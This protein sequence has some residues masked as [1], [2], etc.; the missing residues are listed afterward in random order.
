[1]RRTIPSRRTSPSSCAPACYAVPVRAARSSIART[2]K[3]HALSDRVSRR[4]LLRRTS[5]TLQSCRGRCGGMLLSGAREGRVAQIEEG[6]RQR[7]EL[8]AEGDVSWTLWGLVVGL[9]LDFSERTLLPTRSQRAVVRA[10]EHAPA[11]DI[12]ANDYDLNMRSD[13][14]SQF[15]VSACCSRCDDL[16]PVLAVIR[17]HRSGPRRRVLKWRSVFRL[18]SSTER[19]TSIAASG[20]R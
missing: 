17:T 16:C 4:R 11:G 7:Q 12:V 18:A 2:S 13:D 1:M 10:C 20:D 5:R 15:P 9:S 19:S 8:I 14:A 3:A 6:C